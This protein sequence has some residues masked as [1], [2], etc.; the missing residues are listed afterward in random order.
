MTNEHEQDYSDIRKYL[1]GLVATSFVKQ[2]QFRAARKTLDSLLKRL[3]ADGKEILSQMIGEDEYSD[4]RESQ[5]DVQNASAIA[6]AIYEKK[7]GKRKIK[8]FADIFSDEF[9]YFFENEQDSKARKI[10]EDADIDYSKFNDKIS[11]AQTISKNPEGFSKDDVK[12]AEE[13]LKK[14]APAFRLISVL[15]EHAVKKLSDS[16]Y[17]DAT[18]EEMNTIVRDYNS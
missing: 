3:D 4:S 8:E 11:K 9:S 10:L 15:Q 14:Y 12:D 5:A 13:T 7:I 1:P 2:K 17:K 6:M 16:A 18:K